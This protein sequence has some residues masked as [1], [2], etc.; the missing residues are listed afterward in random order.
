MRVRR[1]FAPYGVAMALNEAEKKFRR[2]RGCGA[3]N[4]LIAALDEHQRQLELDN[5]EAIA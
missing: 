1:F 4:H 2:I 5:E 3:M